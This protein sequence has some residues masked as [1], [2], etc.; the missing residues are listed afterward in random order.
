M[1]KTQLIA[2]LA[3]TLKVSKRMANDMVNAFVDSVVAGVK[4]SGEVRI[5]GFGTFKK[6]ARKARVGVNPRK[7]EEKINIPAMNV[8]TFKA[9]SDFKK[10]IR[11]SK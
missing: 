2:H 11:D 3:E 5:Q 6:S 4:K 1:T 8:P 9:G 7:P 10:A